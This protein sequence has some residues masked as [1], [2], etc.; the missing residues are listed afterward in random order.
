MKG[1]VVDERGQAID[2]V[3]IISR[4]NISPYSLFWR[5]H[6]TPTLGGRF[7]LAGLAEGV[8]YPVY[9]LDPKRRLGAMEIIQAGDKERTF[10]LKPC[11]QATLRLIDE[12]GEPVPGNYGWTE[13]VVT[14]GA[15]KFD[16]AAAERGELAADADFIANIDRANN[17]FDA[18]DDD[19]R[20]RLIALIPGATYRVMGKRGGEICVVKEFKVKANERVDLGD[21]TVEKE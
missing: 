12:K 5:G 1:R 13:M 21:I 3:S 19:G 4:L 11:G 20:R 14:P 8:E 2:E 15:S 10:V 18:G 6:T 9:F 16:R 7:E 17:P